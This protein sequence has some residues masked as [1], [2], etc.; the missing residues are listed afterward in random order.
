MMHFKGET[1]FSVLAASSPLSGIPN[2]K[3]TAL[4]PK[5][6]LECGGLTCSLYASLKIK[7]ALEAL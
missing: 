4:R 1:D 3:G 6:A 7:R 5:G 2:N